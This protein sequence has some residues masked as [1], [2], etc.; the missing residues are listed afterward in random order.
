[1][2]VVGVVNR[3]E[4]WDFPTNDSQFGSC[5]YI[6]RLEGKM[7]QYLFFDS[8]SIKKYGVWQTKDSYRCPWT[9]TKDR[10][11][12]VYYCKSTVCNRHTECLEIIT[13]LKGKHENSST[14]LANRRPFSSKTNLTII[15]KGKIEYGWKW[16]AHGRIS[17]MFFLDYSSPSYS[18]GQMC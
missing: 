5:E 8:L 17:K 10:P 9:D 12:M 6:A 16:L 1:M 18:V 2:G 4:N 3:V 14:K 11:N 13:T 7:R 15:C